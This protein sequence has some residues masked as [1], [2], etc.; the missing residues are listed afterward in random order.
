IEQAKSAGKP[1]I[2]DFTADWCLP[3]KEL[4]N[5][6]FPDKDVVELSKSFVM[7]KADVTTGGSPEVESLKKKFNVAGVPTIVFLDKSGV[8]RVELRVVGF[9]EAPVFLGKMKGARGG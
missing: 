1:V 7:L 3:C 6:T 9:V 2:V 4:E 5:F 8:E